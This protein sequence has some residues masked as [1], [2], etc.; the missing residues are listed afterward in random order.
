MQ[1]A[2][3]RVSVIRSSYLGLVTFESW[4]HYGRQMRA[5]FVYTIE[6]C[7]ALPLINFKNILFTLKANL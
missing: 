1:P 5:L 6:R 3:V 2:E 7:R 4:P